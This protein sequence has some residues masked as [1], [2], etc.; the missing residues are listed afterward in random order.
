[1]RI[2][3]K[4]EKLISDSRINQT[5]CPSKAMKCDKPDYI[6]ASRTN[7]VHTTATRASD[8]NHISVSYGLGFCHGREAPFEQQ[9]R[10]GCTVRLKS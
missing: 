5:I 7:D 8:E 9:R 1:M 4:R 10:T 6:L 3:R 2:L